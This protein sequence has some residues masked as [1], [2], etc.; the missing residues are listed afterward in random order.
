MTSADNCH[1]KISK[2]A[3]FTIAEALFVFALISLVSVFLFAIFTKK[4]VSAVPDRLKSDFAS[5]SAIIDRYNKRHLT[6]ICHAHLM[7]DSNEKRWSRE[8][9]K[10]WP[11]SPIGTVYFISHTGDQN[12]PGLNDFYYIGVALD[13]QD[14]TMFDLLYDDNNLETGKFRHQLYP[15]EHYSYYLSYITSGS[16]SHCTK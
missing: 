6:P 7:S 12:N 16:H 14:A 11:T 1:Y 3:G 8:V 5:I 4:E 10:T 13:E 2:K 15:L 9:N